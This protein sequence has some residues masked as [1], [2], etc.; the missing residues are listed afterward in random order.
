MNSVSLH[1]DC[2]LGIVWLGVC[3]LGTVQFHPAGLQLQP[4][5]VTM[6]DH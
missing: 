3:G 5:L 1:S 2:I 6:Y 4:S